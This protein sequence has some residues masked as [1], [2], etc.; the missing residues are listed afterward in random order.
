[1]ARGGPIRHPQTAIPVALITGIDG[2][3]AGLSTRR[4]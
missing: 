2:R 3:T 1:M 4:E